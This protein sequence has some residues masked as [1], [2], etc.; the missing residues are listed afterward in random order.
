MTPELESQ[1]K[2]LVNLPSPPG[3]ATHIIELAQDPDI[4]MGRVARAVSLD[5]ALTTKIL[6]IANSAI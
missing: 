1:L 3:V 2:S 4:E 5:P 6:R